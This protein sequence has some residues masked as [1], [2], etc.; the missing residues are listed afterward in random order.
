MLVQLLKNPQRGLSQLV[1]WMNL[2]SKKNVL[3]ELNRKL[4][5]NIP[6]FRILYPMG[7][8]FSNTDALCQS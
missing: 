4:N 1:P 5:M 6:Q 8:A 3:H 7:W 2:V